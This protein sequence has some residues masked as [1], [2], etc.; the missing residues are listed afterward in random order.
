MELILDN[1]S[2]LKGNLCKTVGFGTLTHYPI[3]PRVAPKRLISSP[4]AEGASSNPLNTQQQ[5]AEP[6]ETQDAQPIQKF[7][8]P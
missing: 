4:P 3:D 8:T 1:V 2:S 5:R 6:A 7:V